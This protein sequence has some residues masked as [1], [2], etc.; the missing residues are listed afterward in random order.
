MTMEEIKKKC[1][2]LMEIA[3]TT[4]LA[5]IDGDGFP[6][7]R[8]M[9]NLRNKTKYPQYAELFTRHQEDF[10]VYLTT[11]TASEKF[12]QIRANPKVS[13]CF[14]LPEK[15]Q[16]VMLTGQIEIVTDMDIKKELWQDDWKIYYP[17]GCDGPEY[18]ILGLLPARVKCWF[19]PMPQPEVFQINV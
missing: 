4:Y 11:D 14:C 19:Y 13:I 7:I 9:E 16:E 3:K 17:G 10:L 8:P 15:I 6:Q 2:E 1:L 18:N 12:K 5:T